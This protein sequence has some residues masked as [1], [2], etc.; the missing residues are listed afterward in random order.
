MAL[1]S[2]C[3]RY[4]V[5]KYVPLA[6]GSPAALAGRRL[7][8][9][10]FGA[11]TPREGTRPCRMSGLVETPDGTSFEEFIRAAFMDELVA[12]GAFISDQAP[13]TLTGMLDHIDFATVIPM[14]RWTFA[15]TLTSSNG[16]SLSLAESYPHDVGK[17]GEDPCVLTAAAFLPAIQRFIG[18]VLRH[19]NLPELLK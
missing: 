3:A 11:T 14:G 17:V 10:V 9:D 13:I 6:A 18:T 8:V 5:A 7:R 2:A 1:S 16:R 15:V 12:A 4:P 19:P